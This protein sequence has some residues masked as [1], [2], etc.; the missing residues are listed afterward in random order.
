MLVPVMVPVSGYKVKVVFSDV[1]RKEEGGEPVYG[2][3]QPENQTIQV[4]YNN[5]TN[6]ASLTRTLFHEIG[7]AIATISGN[8]EWM[9][10]EKEEAFCEMFAHAGALLF[11]FGPTSGVKYKD[12]DM[13]WEEE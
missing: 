8:A 7:H 4:Y 3:Y 9:G 5:H 13:P 11:T 12:I 6:E 10:G 1:E 2:E